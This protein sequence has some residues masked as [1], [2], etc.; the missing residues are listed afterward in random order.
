MPESF[1][2]PA[3]QQAFGRGGRLRFD[4][5][6]YFRRPSVSRNGRALEHAG[7][8]VVGSFTNRS[9]MELRGFESLYQKYGFL[10]QMDPEM[11]EMDGSPAPLRSMWYPILANG[12]ANEFPLEQIMAFRWFEKKGLEEV[13]GWGNAPEPQKLFP[14]LQQIKGPIVKYRCP[15]CAEP[16]REFVDPGGTAALAKHL[17]IVHEWSRQEMNA[18][19]DRHGISFSEVY[20]DPR[21]T[22]VFDN[23]VETVRE[24]LKCEDC[25]FVVSPESKNPASSLRMHRMNAHKPLQVETVG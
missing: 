12:G 25:D 15:D 8:I 24:A 1:Q 2:S 6:I 11:K 19:G 7:W 4:Q 3:L 22:V 18:W 20:G 9:H 21:S 16:K 10:P 13:F 17:R 14:Q 5:P 23:T